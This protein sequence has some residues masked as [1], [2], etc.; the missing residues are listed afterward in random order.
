MESNLVTFSKVVMCTLCMTVKGIQAGSGVKT[1]PPYINFKFKYWFDAYLRACYHKQGAFTVGKYLAILPTKIFYLPYISNDV[2][3][4]QATH[5]APS[6][7][8]QGS[9]IYK[10]LF[11]R[12]LTIC[13]QFQ[14]VIGLIVSSR[15]PRQNFLYV[16]GS[17]GSAQLGAQRSLVLWFSI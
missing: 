6:R 9:G 14:T 5:S 17:A 11:A 8:I 1:T 15:I 16:L 10:L 4:E 12:T 2:L 3:Y 13:A 7:S